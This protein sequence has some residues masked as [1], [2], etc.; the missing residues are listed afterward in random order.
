MLILRTIIGLL[1]L[2]LI[3][4][5][6]FPLAELKNSAQESISPIGTTQQSLVTNLNGDSVTPTAFNVPQASPSAELPLVLATETASPTN[7][8]FPTEVT[9]VPFSPSATPTDVVAVVYTPSPT[10]T[11]F[12]NA[13][14]PIEIS[15]ANLPASTVELPQDVATVEGEA[16]I[17]EAT[18]TMQP[19]PVSITCA[20]DVDADGI[21]TDDDFTQ[22]GRSLLNRPV[23]NSTSIY[24]LNANS[25]IDIGDLQKMAAFLFE[26]CTH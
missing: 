22:L 11:L 9:S 1:I 19:S 25:Q 20:L 6:P 8:L 18:Q 17:G 23:N 12:P 26:T 24:D 16:T 13:I 5:L 14:V 10:V 2:I 3:L 15:P 7:T 4:G 21:V